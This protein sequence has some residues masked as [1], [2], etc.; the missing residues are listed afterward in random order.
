MPVV[1]EE[2]PLPPDETACPKCGKPAAEMSETE[3]SEVIEV[4]VRAH[5]RQI[6]RKRYRRTCDWRFLPWNLTADRRA[7]LTSP[8]TS[9]PI[10]DSS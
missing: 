9:V 1:E 2:I 7:E 3:E 5:R 8:E 4:E 10:N 6:R